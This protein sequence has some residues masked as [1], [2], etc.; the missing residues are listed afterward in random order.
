[1]MLTL[2]IDPSVLG[3]LKESFPKPKH[4]AEKALLK[5]KELLEELVFKA[6]MR[7][8][9]NYETLLNLYSIPV[10]E[11]THK[12]PQ[13]GP[14]KVRLH[15]WLSENKLSLVETVEQGSNLTGLVS[16]V[17]LTDL[18][19]VTSNTDEL[20]K[21]LAS[22]DSPQELDAE[23]CPDAAQN[24]EAFAALCPDYFSLLSPSQRDQVYD[25]LPVD[26]YSLE[27]YIFWINTKATMIAPG[28]VRVYTEQAM[29]VL[30]VAKHTGGFFPQ[31]RKPSP[32]G[33]TYYSGISIQSVNKELRRG[34]LGDCWE[35]DIR[36]SVVSWKMTFAQELTDEL[37]PTKECRK[38]FWASIWYLEA[39]S[40]FMLDVRT[41]TFGR[42]S[43]L[44]VEFQDSLI[45]QAVT[46]ISFGARANVNGWRAKD[47]AWKSTALV[48]ILK[49]ARQRQCF[50][51]N[52]TISCFIKE[53]VMLDSYL[54]DGMKK[55]LPKVYYGPL[56]TASIRPSKAKAVAYL[57]QKSETMVMD[58]ARNVLAS[59]GIKPIAYIHD[60]FIVQ[61]KLSLD[62]RNEVIQEMRD[63]TG[64]SYWMLKSEK[65]EGFKFKNNGKADVQN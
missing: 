44:D 47:G 55:D 22:V 15:K 59:H 32:F 60:A 2:S 5:Y 52:H 24:A 43:G 18:V 42:K 10:S 33:R 57:Y 29:M 23:L 7:G 46:A 49:N 26:V 27:A 61:K 11:L 14:M 51:E 6:Q 8:R 50:L 63:Q 20:S 38:Q 12:G 48:D 4:S 64:N 45:K 34:I 37:Y 13:I 16:L 39:R 21:Q 25:L 3:K 54:A 65:L 30:A 56:I 19:A 36:S 17:K 35:Y 1:M 28:H 62:V 41:A 9:S 53:Q 31:R 40:E 58:V